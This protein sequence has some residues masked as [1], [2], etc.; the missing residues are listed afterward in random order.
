MKPVYVLLVSLLLLGAAPVTQPTSKPATN[1]R[2]Y[3]Q[4]QFDALVK[5]QELFT[6]KFD[7]FKN[8]TSFESAELA[9]PGGFG[10][11]TATVS[12][13]FDGEKQLASPTEVH[14]DVRRHGREWYWLKLKDVLAFES[15]NA[16]GQKLDIPGALIYDEVVDGGVVEIV[17]FRF[18]RDDLEPLMNFHGLNLRVA[19][20]EL[21]EESSAEI[22]I[23][24]DIAALKSG[25]LGRSSHVKVVS[26]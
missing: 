22:A 20:I 3:T 11:V 12:Y 26:G 17:H 1:I 13:T 9:L 7:K 16:V 25:I 6:A 5:A 8:F 2:T 18:S 24:L 21:N 15:V 19:S 14:L 10:L 23:L 4:S